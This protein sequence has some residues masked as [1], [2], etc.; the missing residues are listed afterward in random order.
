MKKTTTTKTTATKNNEKV[1]ATFSHDVIK[2]IFNDCNVMMKYDTDIYIGACGTA[3]KVNMFSINFKKSLCN[4]YCNDESFNCIQSLQLTAT[5][6][7][8]NANI[9]DK[10][11][12][13]KIT[14]KSIDDIKSMLTAL[15]NNNII[16]TNA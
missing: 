2:S 1:N 14:T 10:T 15:V 13:N 16:V 7:F 12:P 5:E 3:K 11:R 6:L 8:N 9:T 4:I